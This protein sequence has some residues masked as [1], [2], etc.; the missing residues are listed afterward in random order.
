MSIV[1]SVAVAPFSFASKHIGQ[2]EHKMSPVLPLAITSLPNT[3]LNRIASIPCP[4]GRQKLVCRHNLMNF[5]TIADE[6]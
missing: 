3:E 2:T 4:I 6:C 5:D 1:Y